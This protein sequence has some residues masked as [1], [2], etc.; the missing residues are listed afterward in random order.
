MY[1]FDK[2]TCRNYDNSNIEQMKFELLTVKIL[3]FENLEFEI[4]T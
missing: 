4:K 1:Q 2:M 3:A